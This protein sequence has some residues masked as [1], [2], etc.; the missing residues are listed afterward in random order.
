MPFFFSERFFLLI[1]ILAMSLAMGL[2]H[3]GCQNNSYPLGGPYYYKD[4][5]SYKIPF[6]PYNQ[7][8][9]EEAKNLTTYYE[10]HFNEKGQIVSFKKFLKGE[11]EWTDKYFYTSSGKLERR[12]LTKTKPHEKIIQHFDENGNIR[13]PVGPDSG[14]V[15]K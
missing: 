15:L 7:I 6:R 5:E 2:F 11:V 4:W 8:S 12:E 13:E 14:Q 3:S 1:L 9:L 10:A